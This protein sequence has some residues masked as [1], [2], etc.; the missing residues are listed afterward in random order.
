M[1]LD[2]TDFKEEVVKYDDASW[3][4]GGD[5]P[6]ELP[7]ANGATHIAMFLGWALSR[8]LISDYHVS[9]SGAVMDL[10]AGRK[11]T[12]RTFLIDVC[13][14]KLT[15]EDLSDI[16]NAFTEDYYEEHY[17]TDYAELFSEVE[18]LY[19]VEDVWANYDRVADM[20]D[21]RLQAWMGRFINRKWRKVWRALTQKEQKP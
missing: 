19:E 7:A 12:P 6:E 20:L 3:H 16:G 2:G 1:S 14:E 8:R 18:S 10:V 21:V 17:F 4:Y 15:S 5:F 11:M 9:D 13:D